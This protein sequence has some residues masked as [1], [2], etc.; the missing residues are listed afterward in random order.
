MTDCATEL[1]YIQ[2]LLDD[3]DNNAKGTE[4]YA[5]NT[6]AIHQAEM[7]QSNRRSK[8][9]R[10]RYHYNRELVNNGEMK[11]GH[12]DGKHNVADMFT[13]ALDATTFEYLRDLVLTEDV[14]ID[15]K[16]LSTLSP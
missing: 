13:K 15:Y 8:H 16:V 12:I 6:S 14:G 9:I 7:Q 10:R 3:I 4:V 11:L 5:D 1:V 2:E